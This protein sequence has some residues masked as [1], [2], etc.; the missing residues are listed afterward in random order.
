MDNQLGRKSAD[1]IM[2]TIKSLAVRQENTLVS[3]ITLHCLRQD[4]DEGIRNFAARLRGQADVCKF[5]VHCSCDP[6]MEVNFGNQM[7]RDVLIRGLYD[8]EIQQEILGNENQDLDLESTIKIIEAKEAGRRSQASFIAEGALAVSQHKKSKNNVASIDRTAVCEKCHKQFTRPLSYRG[9]VRPHKMCK[10]CFKLQEN[11]A[12]KSTMGSASEENGNLVDMICPAAVTGPTKQKSIV[13]SHH[14]FS[15]DKGWL[16]RR[17]LPQPTV[18]ITV[19]V[20][21]D[22]YIHFGTSLRF[23]PRGG[24]VSAVADTGCQSCLIGSKVVHYLGFRDRDLLSVEH[25]MNAVN[26][27]SIDISGAVI[28][29][30]TGLD[31]GGHQLQQRWTP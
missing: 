1:I 10:Q 12:P 30:L 4:K 27:H 3:R 18:T 8:L 6:G 17:S 25:R 31:K 28:L 19:S 21:N 26:Q 14:V 23:T 11:L 24:E 9:K 13:L 7:I 2:A 5:T 29:R 22:D 20:C 15:D 16:Q